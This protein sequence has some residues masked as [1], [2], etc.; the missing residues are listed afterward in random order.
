MPASAAASVFG[1]RERRRYLAFAIPFGVAFLEHHH[2]G[3]FDWRRPARR[4]RRDAAAATRIVRGDEAPRRPRRGQSSDDESRRRRGRDVDIP[5][6]RGAPATRIVR[7]DEARRRRDRNAD[8]PPDRPG[9]GKRRTP[10]RLERGTAAAAP[11]L[12]DHDAP[13]TDGPRFQLMWFIV[14]IILC[15]C[16]PYEVPEGWVTNPRW[17]AA[18]YVQGFFLVD[19]V[20]T[21][22]FVLIVSGSGKFSGLTKLF[23]LPRLIKMLRAFK[24]AKM[25]QAYKMDE[26]AGPRGEPGEADGRRGCH[27]WRV[28]GGGSRRRRGCRV[29]RPRVDRSGRPRRLVPRPGSRASCNRSS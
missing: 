25:T 23:K 15:F 8:Y 17:I 19:V 24:L 29:D 21:F 4:E 16:T 2:F 14:D 11:R 12:D 10:P 26:S 6:R 27:V 3:P 5:R 18:E 28:R 1:E 20:S 22:P 7:G 9:S 13:T